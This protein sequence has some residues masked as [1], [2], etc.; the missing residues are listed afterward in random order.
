MSVHVIDTADA[1]TI[2]RCTVLG[3]VGYPFASGELLDLSFGR[4]NL[5]IKAN[6]TLPID[7]PYFEIVDISISGPGSV[8]SG[9]GFV[10]GGFGVEGAVEGIAAATVLNF[11]TTRTKIHTFITILSHVGELHLHYSS[12]E[13][14][15]LR[16]ALSGVFTTL[17]RL[18]PTWIRS[19]LE[20]LEHQHTAELIDKEEFERLKQRLLSPPEVPT[21]SKVSSAT[22]DE[23]LEQERLEGPNGECPNCESIIPLLSLE[24]PK[25]TVLFGN[26][27][28]W[29]PK[30]I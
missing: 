9:G 18:D 8:T 14:S 6:G 22:K 24:C 12:M 30:P 25:C 23:P 7:V 17:R 26:G 27:S 20:R 15:A 13:P 2:K 3:G 10:G 1:I 21:H 29:K 4:Q 28:A 5:A 16:I 11:L 19:R